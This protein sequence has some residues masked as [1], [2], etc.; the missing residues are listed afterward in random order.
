[1][2]KK[3]AKFI[4]LNDDINNPKF[5]FTNKSKFSGLIIKLLGIDVNPGDVEGS[6]PGMF[7]NY[8]IISAPAGYKNLPDKMADVYQKELNQILR[9]W[10]KFR[11]INFKPSENLPEDVK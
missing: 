9:E 8:Q 3:F 1:M 11:L 5:L 7:L 4:W 10:Y 6:K 2:K